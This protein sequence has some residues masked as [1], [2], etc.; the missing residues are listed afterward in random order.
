[1]KTRIL[2]AGDGVFLSRSGEGWP[3]PGP[4]LGREAVLREVDQLRETWDADALRVTGDFID[5]GDR[6]READVARSGART[7]GRYGL[8]RRLHAAAR[9][10][11]RHRPV[12]GEH[13]QA[14]K[15]VGL[16]E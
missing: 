8:Q 6:G 15:A 4:F 5:V 12:F 13:E 2:R 1:M 10:G 9:Q 11:H 3:E 7:A 16:E 14:L